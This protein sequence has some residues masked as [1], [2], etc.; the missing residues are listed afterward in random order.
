MCTLQIDITDTKQVFKI[1]RSLIQLLVFQMFRWTL[2]QR[3]VWMHMNTLF[4]SDACSTEAH[5]QPWDHH[6]DG[7][8]G[9]RTC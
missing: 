4:G 2:P 8:Q 6:S 9:G 1:P 5:E 7:Y 3:D